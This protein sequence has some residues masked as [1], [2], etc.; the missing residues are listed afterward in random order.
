MLKNCYFG[1]F[2]VVQW[3][4]LCVFFALGPGSILVGELR[5]HKSHSVAKKKRERKKK[6]CYFDE[7]LLN[8][9]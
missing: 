2:S 8:E 3:L 9:C 1:E 7:Y 6:N 4:R 5:P